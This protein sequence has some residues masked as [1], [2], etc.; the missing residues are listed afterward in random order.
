MPG[1]AVRDRRKEKHWR[2]IVWAHASSGLSVGAW[3]RTHGV[4]EPSFCRWRIELARRACRIRTQGGRGARRGS[5]SLGT[6]RERARNRRLDRFRC[7]RQYERRRTGFADG[8]VEPR[9]GGVEADAGLCVLVVPGDIVA[10]SRENG[11]GSDP[12]TVPAAI[13]GCLP[14]LNTAEI[15]FADSDMD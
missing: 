8:G 14:S 6:R 15:P 10:A 2:R 5:V 11:A 3:C 13:A 7:T 9:A 12:P 1:R 4:K